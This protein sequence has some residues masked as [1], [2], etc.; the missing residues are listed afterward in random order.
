MN[1]I[2]IMFVLKCIYDVFFDKE[3]RRNDK[4]KSNAKYLTQFR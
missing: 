4:S 3:P 1:K 2:L